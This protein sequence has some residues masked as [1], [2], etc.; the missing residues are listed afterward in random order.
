MSYER[1]DL[2]VPHPVVLRPGH[3][4]VDVTQEAIDEARASWEDTCPIEVVLG[5]DFERVVE[6]PEGVQ[7]YMRWFDRGLAVRPWS[8]QVKLRPRYE[9]SSGG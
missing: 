7:L 4:M 2:L 6:W 3:V 1:D 8:F 9:D 5:D